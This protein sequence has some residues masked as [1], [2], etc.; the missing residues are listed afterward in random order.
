LV[1]H[2]VDDV[3]EGLVAGKK[4]MPA[5]EQIAFEPALARVLGEDLHHTPVHGEVIVL[6]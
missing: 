6:G 4:S 2:G 5:G 1:E 3:D